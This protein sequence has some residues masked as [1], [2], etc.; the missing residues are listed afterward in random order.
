MADV[1]GPCSTLPYSR[2]ASPD[3]ARCDQHPD[4][5]ATGRI[6]GET[7]S[8]G[9]EYHDLCHACIDEMQKHR[10]ADRCGFCEWC[11]KEATDLRYRRDLDE[12]M[13]GPLYKVCGEC[14]RSENEEATRELEESDRY[15]EYGEDD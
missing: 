11:K 7:D 3:G 10:E 12:G 6:Q 1:S 2:S 14:V 13:S 15:R 8:F 9:A 4:R 5:A